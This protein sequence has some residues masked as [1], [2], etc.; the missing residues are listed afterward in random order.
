[1][2]VGEG[3]APPRVGGGLVGAVSQRGGAP[4]GGGA[5]PPLH[6]KLTHMGG[7]ARVAW[8]RPSPGAVGRG[9][10]RGD[11]GEGSPAPLF[12]RGPSH[13]SGGGCP[14]SPCRSPGASHSSR[15]PEGFSSGAGGVV[16]SSRSTS[17]QRTCRP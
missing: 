2:H 9:G 13:P 1:F 6:Q 17:R 3:L 10:G 15:K 16:S 14:A 7:K 4:P 11:G 12:L 5:G 8:G